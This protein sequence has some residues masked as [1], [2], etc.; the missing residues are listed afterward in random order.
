MKNRYFD[1]GRPGYHPWRKVKVCL[2][3]LRY[4]AVYDFSVAYKLLVSAVAL[5]VALW[6][7]EW[8]DVLLVL[9][10]TGAMLAAEIFNSVFEAMCDY[11]QPFK[12]ADIQAIKDMAAA[13]AGIAILTWFVVLGVELGRGIAHFL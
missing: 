5:G 11:L 9:V 10:A 6:L 2:S 4:A 3:G 13:G 7:N 1:T 12:D 8:V